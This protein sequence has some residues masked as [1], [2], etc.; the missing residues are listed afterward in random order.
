MTRRIP[1]NS[2]ENCKSGAKNP[3][4]S[5]PVEVAGEFYG[6]DREQKFE[7]SWC[8]PP[9]EG[10]TVKPALY[11][12]SNR[13]PKYCSR[14]QAR[15]RARSTIGDEI[16]CRNYSGPPVYCLPRM[17]RFR[18]FIRFVQGF[19]QGFVGRV[20]CRQGRQVIVAGQVLPRT[21]ERF[22]TGLR[23][24]FANETKFFRT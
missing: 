4:I 24:K 8:H 15:A 14:M 10:N 11:L 18:G 22:Q 21:I 5:W 19:T 6:V 13:P 9:N 7:T 20:P 1:L 17:C 2:R 3:S 12:P 23:R 16:A